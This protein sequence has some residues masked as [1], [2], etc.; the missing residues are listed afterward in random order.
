MKLKV[1]SLVELRE[2]PNSPWCKDLTK[3]K[4]YVVKSPLE[5][6]GNLSITDDKG[7]DVYILGKVHNPSDRTGYFDGA[8]YEGLINLLMNEEEGL[9]AMFIPLPRSEWC[10]DLTKGKKYSVTFV[11]DK[12]HSYF[13]VTND[14]G[15][16]VVI[17]DSLLIRQTIYFKEIVVD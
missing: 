5:G 7:D 11:D 1:G 14:L 6:E 2:V 17:K 4:V 9:E 10:K 16:P 12:H 8:D 15:E 13:K 3:G